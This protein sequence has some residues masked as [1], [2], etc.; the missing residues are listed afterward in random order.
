MRTH[1]KIEFSAGITIEQAVKELLEYKEKGE[2]VCGEFNGT[3][4]FSDTV[5]MDT[6]YLELTGKTKSE[7][8]KEQ[9]EW[10]ED[11]DKRKHEHKNQIP[12]LV[13]HW[14]MKGREA[15]TEDKWEYWDKIVP[16]RLNDLYRGMELGACLEIIE[17]LNRKGTLDEAKQKI[18]DQG[19][20]GMSFSLVC[21]MVKEFSERGTEFVNYVK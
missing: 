3:T 5:T 1:R 11:Y 13:K 20:S 19:H 12:E 2:L 10:K 14:M 9:Q 6:A 4:L 8:D 15:L 7:F 18:E 17:V 16:V 21:A